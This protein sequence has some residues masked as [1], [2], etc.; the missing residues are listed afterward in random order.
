VS[1]YVGGVLAIQYADASEKT[2]ESANDLL[3]RQGWEDGVL[4]ARCGEEAL[5]DRSRRGI[6]EDADLFV[7]RNRPEL[8]IQ[9]ILDDYL[10]IHLK[11]YESIAQ[12]AHVPNEGRVDLLVTLADGIRYVVEVKWIG[13]ALKAA[14]DLETVREKLKAKWKCSYVLV[15]DDA[16]ARSGVVQMSFYHKKLH[17]DRTYLAAYDCRRV[18]DRKP[19]SAAASYPAAPD[20]GSHQYRVFHVPVDPR[21]ASVKA[22]PA[23]GAPS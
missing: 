12:E 9:S 15:L 7:L 1:V 3:R 13:R 11:G 20:L 8:L 17:P 22:R 18:S 19:A 10:H 4:L 23:T 14:V 16:A 6:W 21:T 5:P 2:I